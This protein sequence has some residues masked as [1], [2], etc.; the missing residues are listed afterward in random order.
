MKE[1]RLE[2]PSLATLHSS[3]IIFKAG[4]V[5]E[6]TTDIEDVAV[7]LISD[8]CALNCPFSHVLKSRTKGGLATR[9]IK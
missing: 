5:V 7:R 4:D 3:A 8:V 9:V 1:I 6:E 2:A